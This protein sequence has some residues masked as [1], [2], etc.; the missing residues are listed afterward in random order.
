[1][2]IED[3]FALRQTAEIYARG[4]D[5][6]CKDDWQAILTADVEIVGPGFHI[7]GLENNL[8]SI[9]MLCQMYSATRHMVHN[10]TATIH[11]DHAVGETYCTAE[12]LLLADGQSKILSWALRYQD[13][14]RREDG[15]WKIARR[16]LIIDWE[17]E[18]PL[19]AVASA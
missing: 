15:I 17:E 3:H 13:E 4:A 12:H 14:W 19:K 6:R 2:A 5:R 1:M 11:G 16:E 8:N 10:Q 9:D 18:R 7:M